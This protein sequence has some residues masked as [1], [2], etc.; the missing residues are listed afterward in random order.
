M[1]NFLLAIFFLFAIMTGSISP[2][3]ATEKATCEI[4]SINGTTV[5]LDCGAQAK[6]FNDVKT[7]TVKKTKKNDLLPG[8]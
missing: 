7:V 2:V 1:P 5:L 3:H 4:K 8:C 6:K